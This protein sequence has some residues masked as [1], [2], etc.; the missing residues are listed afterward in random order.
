MKKPE[1]VK[2]EKAELEPTVKFVR[3]FGFGYFET[4][5]DIDSAETELQIRQHRILFLCILVEWVS[6]YYYL[7][8]TRK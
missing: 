6:F 8:K 4:L 1:D 5:L 2:P 7:D 3:G